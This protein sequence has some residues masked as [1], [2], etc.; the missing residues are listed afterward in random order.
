LTRYK[1][2]PR[3]GG[4]NQTKRKSVFC[5]V[6]GHAFNSRRK[7]RT[8]EIPEKGRK[9]SPERRR[10][11]D[12]AGIKRARECPRRSQRPTPKN[13]YE[14]ETISGKRK[15]DPSWLRKGRCTAIVPV[16]L[17]AVGERGLIKREF[18][19]AIIGENPGSGRSCCRLEGYSERGGLLI[20]D[21]CEKPS[22][23]N[24]GRGDPQRIQKCA[25]D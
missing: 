15:S 10:A 9:K 2:L 24:G 1:R 22:S 11:T 23:T 12:E 4:A 7:E 6:P 8:R 5:T 25:S 16:F 20:V 13:P 18:P 3:R 21:L 17:Q 14:K 19:P